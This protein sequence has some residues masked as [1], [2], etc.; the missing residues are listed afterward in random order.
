MSNN[1]VRKPFNTRAFISTVMFTSG[2]FLPFSGLMNHILQFEEMTIA[3][4]FWMSVH[5]ISGL[6]FAIILVLIVVGLFTSHVFHI[7]N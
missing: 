1:V 3:R 2:L 4:H 6:L 7:R 5:D